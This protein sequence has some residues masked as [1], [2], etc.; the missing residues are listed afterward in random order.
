MQW[1]NR[2][3]PVG[4]DSEIDVATLEFDTPIW[5]T[6]PAKVKSMGVIT[7][8][9]TNIF[10][11]PSGDIDPDFLFGQPAARVNATPGNF[12]IFV[13]A[14]QIKLLAG[15]EGCVKIT[16]GYIVA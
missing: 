7:S 4:A 16:F 11:E 15:Y 6:P 10:T 3:I 12:G 13:L 14:N 2:T 1:S 8:I 5:I 9:I